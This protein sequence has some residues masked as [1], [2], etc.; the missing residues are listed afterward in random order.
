MGDRQQHR[1]IHGGPRRAVCLYAQECLDALRAEGHT[2]APGLAGENV[3]I[4]GLTWV[5]VSVGDRVRIGDEVELEITG[6]AAPCR[7]NAQWFSD[8][9]YERLSQKRHPGWSRLYACVVQAGTIRQ[10][11]VVAHRQ[12]CMTTK[13][14]VGAVEEDVPV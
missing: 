13:K 8:G 4:A 2:I 5:A 9:D 7:A 1:N 11:D 10:G 3:T 14:A 12:G 6:Y